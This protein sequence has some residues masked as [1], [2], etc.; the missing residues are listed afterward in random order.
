MK[1]QIVLPN[2]LTASSLCCGL[3]VIFK[4]NMI[5][6]G[7]AVFDQVQY[8]TK[9]LLLAS[10]LDVLDGA[11]A[12]VM[13]VESEFGGFFDSMADSVSFG[14]APSVL[15]LK[16]LSALPGTFLSWCLVASAMTY[17]IGG[18][19]RL[20]RF[21]TTP[22]STDPEK[23]GT[24]T[25]LPITAGAMAAVSPTLLLM[26]EWWND[27]WPMSEL[28]RSIVAIVGLFIL[29]YLMVSR[30]RFPSLKAINV[31]VASVQLIIA[32][33][34]VSSIVLLLALNNFSVALFLFSWGYVLGAWL[35]AC[36]R[37]AQGR[38]QCA[39]DDSVDKEELPPKDAPSDE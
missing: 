21:S 31:R 34:C 32:V 4:M 15:V 33:A 8:C 17:S 36:I 9:I 26:S 5:H 16:T 14:I 12:R 11:L 10:V 23:K 19:L 30:W 37:L 1:R 13:K 2:L 22:P 39:I 27:F 38:R 18:V 20:V 3:F 24:F 25:G 35:L 7:T 29:G 6:P 28:S